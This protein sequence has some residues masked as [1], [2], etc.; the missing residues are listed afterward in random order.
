MPL[1]CCGPSPLSSPSVKVKFLISKHTDRPPL[2]VKPPAPGVAD[3]EPPQQFHAQLM[4]QHLRVILPRALAVAVPPPH[5]QSLHALDIS[6]R[7]PRVP[8]SRHPAAGPELIRI[9]PKHGLVTMDDVCRGTHLHP[10]R[11]KLAVRHDVTG[12]WDEPREDDLRNRVVA[13]GLLDASGEERERGDG[14]IIGGN[15]AGETADAI[16]SGDLGNDA[17]VDGG[18]LDQVV[19]EGGDEGGNTV[20]VGG[21]KD[22][23]FRFKVFAA[24]LKAVKGLLW[25]KAGQDLA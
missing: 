23:G 6:L 22:D 2:V 16:G 24:V 10:T 17:G 12:S 13:K 5:A 1:V 7:R 4:N 15:G 3:L 8:L 25:V 11:D 19:D 9:R 21:L 18:V 20:E 14:L